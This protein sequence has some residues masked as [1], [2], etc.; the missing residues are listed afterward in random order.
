M[1]GLS[2]KPAWLDQIV[3]VTATTNYEKSRKS[4]IFEGYYRTNNRRKSMEKIILAN[5]K[6]HLS[7]HHVDEW[8]TTFI[9]GFRQKEGLEVV[10]APPFL[11]MERVFSRLRKEQGV[12]LAAQGVSPYPPG[13]YTGAT[14]ARWLEAMA[15]YVLVGHRERRRYFHETISDLA[16]QVRESVAV[17]IKPILC[18]DGE[19]LAEMKA[20]LDMDELQEL[21]VAY[22]PDS[23]VAL[24]TAPEL[25]SIE[26][27]IARVGEYFP[28]CPVL[29]GG[30]VGPDNGAE[31]LGL[32]GINGLLVG[33]NCLDA[34]RF[35]EL[36]RSL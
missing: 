22:T 32:A 6:A 16:A 33:R 7:G 11:Y 5:W 19:G 23:A 36:V 12:S 27:E 15:R 21:M 30:G 13:N 4:P 29:Y 31:I 10:V 2:Y 25:T 34:V 17:G 24:E 9:G 35:G 3:Q 8:L 14:P 26:K 28:G 1:T 20:A 18:L